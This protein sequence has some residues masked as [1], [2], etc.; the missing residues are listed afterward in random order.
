M[1]RN[2]ASPLTQI[3]FVVPWLGHALELLLPSYSPTETMNGMFRLIDE[4]VAQHEDTVEVREEATIPSRV[5]NRALSKPDFT[6][7][8]FLG[9]IGIQFRSV[10]E[11]IGIILSIVISCYDAGKAD[12]GNALLCT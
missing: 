11:M 9:G 5:A 6:N 7:L 1:V 3:G 8:V 4:M 2:F 12:G 10:H